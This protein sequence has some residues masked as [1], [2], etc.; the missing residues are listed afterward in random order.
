MFLMEEKKPSLNLI[1]VQ[2][3]EKV[4]SCKETKYQVKDLKYEI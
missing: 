2:G 4:V 3:F 1:G